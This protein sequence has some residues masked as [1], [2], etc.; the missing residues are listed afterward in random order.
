MCFN[1]NPRDELRSVIFARIN[2]NIRSLPEKTRESVLEAIE[3]ANFGVFEEFM[4][5][6]SPEDE[7]RKEYS[8]LIEEEEFNK[9]FSKCVD[10]FIGK[11]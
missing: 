4:D 3:E 1:I 10:E 9:L 8:G 7:I 6:Y 2:R 11:I 5:Y